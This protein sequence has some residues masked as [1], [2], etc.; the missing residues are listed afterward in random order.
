MTFYEILQTAGLPAAY[1][2]FEEDQQPPFVVYYGGGQDQFH[3][4]NE[5]Y[6]KQNSYQVE[7]YFTAKDEAA[8][9]AIE[10]VFETNGYF[11]TKSPDTYID[12]Q[13]VSV[14]YY[15]VWR[16]GF[17]DESDVWSE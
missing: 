6:K 16:K 11:F 17:K 10:D 7:Y 12:D 3:A 9:G 14:I 1:S 2:H 4:D 8:E 15:E 5:I 13:E